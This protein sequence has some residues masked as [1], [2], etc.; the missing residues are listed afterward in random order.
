MRVRDLID[1]LL[2][3][4][5]DKSACRE[6]DSCAFVPKGRRRKNVVPVVVIS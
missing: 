6:P 2:Q 3:Q 5:Q 4:N 1:L